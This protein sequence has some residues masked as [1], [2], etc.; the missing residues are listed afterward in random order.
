MDGRLP[1]A[2]LLALAGQAAPGILQ[3]QALQDALPADHP[4]RRVALDL[5]SI[6]A[7][8]LR[9]AGGGAYFPTL[10]LASAR[11]VTNLDEPTAVHF[12]R[13]DDYLLVDEGDKRTYRIA[14]D[15][16]TSIGISSDEY[17][18]GTFLPDGS[19]MVAGKNGMSVGGAKPVFFSG[20]WG[21]KTRQA[22]K[23]RSL[24]ALSGG[25]VIAI[26]RDFDGL[27]LCKAGGVTC[28]PWG[29]AGKFRSVKVGLSDFVYVLDD[30]KKAVRVLDQTG[31]QL[32]AAGPTIGTV[33][34]GEIVDLAV[35]E[36]YGV[37]LLD[38]ETKR[39]EILALRSSPENTLSLV[40][41]GSTAI[42]TEGERALRDA[43]AIGIAP[44]GS[45]LLA[46][47]SATRF[48]TLQ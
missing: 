23:I 13:P 6:L 5:A 41:L 45:A 33:K 15:A 32:A 4:D 34:F 19:V 9:L 42:P 10:G 24:A 16:A 8:R 1:L 14:R 7:R 28:A 18:A 3:S 22:R 37:Y 26:E 25:D 30:N 12:A 31:R 17:G 48:L 20:G 2:R 46:G 47:R 39:V 27:L 40:A 44:G 36:A 38:K 21:G 43:S 29:P 11:G 35:D